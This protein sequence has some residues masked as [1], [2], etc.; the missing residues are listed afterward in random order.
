MSSV[1]LVL[2]L[3]VVVVVVLAFVVVVVIVLAFVAVGHSLGDVLPRRCLTCSRR[4]RMLFKNP[5]FF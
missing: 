3:V 2:V 1:N 5:L 4:L